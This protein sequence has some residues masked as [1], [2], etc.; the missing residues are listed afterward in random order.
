MT[1][2][3]SSKQAKLISKFLFSAF[4]MVFLTIIG[5]RKEQFGS[6]DAESTKDAVISNPI[7]TDAAKD[8]FTS[9]YGS[10][11]HINPA[12]STTNLTQ[13]GDNYYFNETFSIEPIWSLAKSSSYRRTAPI[14]I[15]PV[16]PIPFLD[17]KEQKYALVVYRDSL[18]QLQSKLQV[19]SAIASYKHN[20]KKEKV[21]DFSGI[22][23]QVAMDG[24]VH[25]A[26][27]AV[28][29][30]FTKRISFGVNRNLGKVNLHTRGC[31]GLGPSIWEEILC[32]LRNVFDGGGWDSSTDTAEPFDIPTP[33]DY[34]LD[35]GG[36][37]YP[38]STGGSGSTNTI[39][40]E[41]DDT[42]FDTGDSQ[43]QLVYYQGLYV[44]QMG[45]LDTEFEVLYNDKKLFTQ[46]EHYFINQGRGETQKNIVRQHEA[47]YH[48]NAKY[49]VKFSSLSF[50]DQTD[51]MPTCIMLKQLESDPI[52]LYLIL[53]WWFSKTSS[54]RAQFM[55]GFGHQAGELYDG[56]AGTV[57]FFEKW[58]VQLLKNGK[59]CVTGNCN[60]IPPNL[61][62][63]SD[64]V[65]KL[66][67]TYKEI[68][69]K[70]IAGDN[71]AQGQLMFEAAML[72]VPIEEL[73]VTKAFK[74]NYLLRGTSEGFAGSAALRELGITPTSMNP[75][76]A[77][78]FAI[79]SRNF[80]NGVLHIAK[81]ETLQSQ[82]I[83]IIEGNVLEQ[84]EKEIPLTI[85]PIDFPSKSFIT[86]TAERARQILKEMGIDL[87][88][89]IT[90]DGG[91]M[92]QILKELPE[93]TKEQIE[94]FITKAK[95]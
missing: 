17:A 59:Y 56:I 12:S 88:S 4:L 27:T 57:T 68:I 7:S 92:D 63:E 42:L 23:Y 36:S 47:L 60:S 91:Q 45:F 85:Q 64:F 20:N 52:T 81:T 61:T 31:F 25:H 82:G 67:N 34:T 84:I 13:N 94:I 50:T 15:V 79:E 49:R 43:V 55:E 2:N 35:Y 51:L 95:Q 33:I 10:S 65:I 18:N 32:V 53:N 58:T 48:S 24:H 71:F 76:V 41:I 38:T 87:P 90:K 78:V 39:N 44:L 73:Q 89:Y 8:W 40:S 22:M 77:T 54:E 16:Q 86:I 6:L 66:F 14:L 80:G 74:P 30:R 29:G 37:G 19:Y 83:K 1:S 26:A 72:I 93:M 3:L 70:A 46:V 5:C 62:I 21:K 69:K 75:A 11:K 28:N 9:Q